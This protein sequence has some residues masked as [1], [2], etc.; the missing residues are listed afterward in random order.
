VQPMSQV[1]NVAQYAV[2]VLGAP[3]YFGAWHKDAIRFLTQH[4]QA[5]TERSVAIFA[6]GP[7]HADPE[8]WQSSREQLDQ[9]LAK[10]PWLVPAAV[11]MFGGKY[12]P[13][14]LHLADKLIASLP[15]SP[16]HGMPASDVCDWNAIR[17]WASNL[18]VKLEPA[19]AQ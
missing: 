12:D 6:L 1:R 13:A 5:L 19:L 8:E 2:V 14:K 3:L 7:T 4:Q 17:N 9:Q 10:F 16:L 11:E 15:A 18:V